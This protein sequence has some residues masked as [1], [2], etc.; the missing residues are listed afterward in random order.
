MQ[1]F[2]VFYGVRGFAKLN[3]YAIRWTRMVTEKAQQ[4]FKILAFW[5][6]YGL[7]AA[8]EAY[9]VKERTLY[10]WQAKLQKKNRRV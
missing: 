10:I 6:K 3:D 7:D 2:R 9:V 1:V 4:K 8:R 5:K